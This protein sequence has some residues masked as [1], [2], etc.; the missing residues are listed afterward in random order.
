MGKSA[1][2]CPN[3]CNIRADAWPSAPTL[4][5]FMSPCAPAIGM[6]AQACARATCDAF[7]TGVTAHTA[8][9]HAAG[10]DAPGG[11]RLFPDSPMAAALTKGVLAMAA[12]IAAA[13]DAGAGPLELVATGALTN[14]ALCL[15][16]FPEYARPELVRV[17]I[18]GG[19][20]GIG[21]TG[22]VQV[23]AKSA[24][25]P[26]AAVARSRPAR[27]DAVLSVAEAQCNAW[28]TRLLLA[29]A[30]CGMC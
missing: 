18:M 11:G 20:L 7:L 26:R 14:V 28:L 4:G 27:D 5:V 9:H 1:D 19:A 22:P 2:A 29:V 21:N 8:P 12:A 17:T 6:R 24:V 23:R 15:T 30:L 25:R 16:L 13:A 3:I 10:L